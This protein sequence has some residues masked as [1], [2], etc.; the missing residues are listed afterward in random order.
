MDQD[1]LYN[2]LHQSIQNYIDYA[3]I[4]KK[5]KYDY[6]IEI[7]GMVNRYDLI[8]NISSHY[9]STSKKIKI[10]TKVS[11]D[12]LYTKQSIGNHDKIFIK[13]TLFPTQT[14]LLQQDIKINAYSECQK[15]VRVKEEL[16]GDDDD[17]NVDSHEPMPIVSFKKEQIEEYLLV[18]SINDDDHDC[19]YELYITPSKIII[20]FSLL[21]EKS[22]VYLYQLL[23][24]LLAY[25]FTGYPYIMTIE[26]E[27]KIRNYIAFRHIKNEQRL[28]LF[29]YLTDKIQ[30]KSCLIKNY[31]LSLPA[32]RFNVDG[33]IF[34]LDTYDNLKKVNKTD[35]EDY[36]Y[37]DQGFMYP[38][39]YYVS[40]DEIVMDQYFNIE[41]EDALVFHDKDKN[42]YSVYTQNRNIYKD[43]IVGNVFIR[44]PFTKLSVNTNIEMKF[45][46]FSKKAMTKEQILDI[47]TISNVFEMRSIVK[48]FC[49]DLDIDF[50]IQLPESYK[51]IIIE[52]SKK[53]K[54]N[55]DKV[56]WIADFFYNFLT[57]EYDEST[58]IQYNLNAIPNDLSKKIVHK[59]EL[60]L[61]NDLEKEKTEINVF[62]NF[63][64]D[65]EK[66]KYYSAVMKLLDQP[67]VYAKE[68]EKRVRGSVTNAWMKCWEM[69][70]TFKLI[71]VDHLSTFTVFCNA[72]F[73]GSFILAI[74]HY[75]KTHT[76]NKKYEWFA[77]SIWPTDVLKNKYKEIYKD[78]FKLYEKYPKRWLM[79]AEN[80]GDVTDLKM[81]EI[82]DDRLKHK[83]DLYTSDVSTGLEINEENGEAR[84][85]LGQ[86]ICG[87]MTLKE[88]GTMV[89]RTHMFFKPFSIS[90]LRILSDLFNEFYLT[91][92][93][94]SRPASSE[95]YIIGKGYKINESVITLLKDVLTH[96][97]VD[98]IDTYIVPINEDFYV[99]VVYSSYYIYERQLHFLKKNMEF[100]R[101][102]YQL[103]KDV[104]NVNMNL[105][106]QAHLNNEYNFRKSI[107]DHWKVKFPVP[108]LLKEDD[109]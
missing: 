109:L 20:S 81:L 11:T 77:N 71:P 31:Y 101:A 4:E 38:D 85:H 16:W 26:E 7:N 9:P 42:E 36:Y 24:I 53:I 3:R 78:S 19:E 5:Q 60:E 72:E 76:N 106:N 29:K 64:Q 25:V 59:K 52:T 91:K 35:K 21:S 57:Y 93:M 69:L 63:G 74:N 82:I 22:T 67:K 99:K 86:V 94:I 54:N 83:V 17:K 92:P 2:I 79:N 13:E 32:I 49:H 102:L 6:K 45:L 27:K 50:L 97:S 55:S 107:V 104:K 51:K 98:T 105:V 8:N 15:S 43:E 103:N 84:N 80:G 30:T 37:I 39:A 62:D 70:N 89:C 1:V 18:K 41:K 96:W 90:L 10:K 47:K 100:T 46:Y 108:N 73:P 33:Y 14:L 68:L 48:R 56:N 87:L 65:I 28:F 66:S 88:G 95:I 34:L 44:E 58:S 75:I 61:C 23:Q 40:L 12:G